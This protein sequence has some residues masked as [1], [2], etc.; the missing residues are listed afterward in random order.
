MDI[1]PATREAA[2]TY[3][4][5]LKK[6]QKYWFYLIKDYEKDTN[7]NY[8]KKIRKENRKIAKKERDE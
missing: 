3:F 1:R 7:C 2:K 4:N 8:I 5:G 6:N